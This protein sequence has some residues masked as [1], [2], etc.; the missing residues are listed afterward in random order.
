MAGGTTQSHHED[1]SEYFL[2]DLLYGADIDDV[3]YIGVEVYGCFAE[4]D[5][6]GWKR[7][8]GLGWSR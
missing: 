3:R 4:S 1:D 8:G 5:R 7:A 2:R 6:K